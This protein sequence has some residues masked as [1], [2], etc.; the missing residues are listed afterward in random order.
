MKRGKAICE[1]LKD[2]RLKI[3]QANGISYTP[4]E[5]HHEGDCAG[6]CNACEQEMRFLERQL[7][8][9]QRAGQAIRVAGVSLGIMAVMGSCQIAQPNGYM[10]P[11]PPTDSTA[12]MPADSTATE[13]IAE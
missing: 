10:E 8:L 5:C 11:Y 6:T 4:K 7:S 13:V 12:N 3:A 2:V 1:T 9:R